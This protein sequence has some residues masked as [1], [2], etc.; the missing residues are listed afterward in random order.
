MISK[1]ARLPVLLAFGIP[2][3]TK[4]F[5][6][7]HKEFYYPKNDSEDGWD[8]VKRMFKAE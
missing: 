2:L 4:N 3:D 6:R 7:P 1:V 8:R 5:D